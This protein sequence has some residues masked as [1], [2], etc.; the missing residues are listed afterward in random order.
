MSEICCY[1]GKVIHT[2]QKAREHLIHLKKIRH[3][4]G[5]IFLCKYCNGYHVGINRHK[6]ILK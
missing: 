6:T 2:K 5:E 1:T 3:Y 4:P